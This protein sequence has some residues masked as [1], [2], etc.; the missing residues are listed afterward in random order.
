MFEKFLYFLILFS[1]YWFIPPKQGHAF[2]LSQQSE[3][4]LLT[5]SPGNEVYSVYGHSAIRVK[6]ITRDWDMVFNYGLFDFSAPNFLYRFAKGHTDYLLGAYEFSVFVEEYVADQRSIYEQVLNLLDAEKQQVFDFL[7]WNARPE[8]R[9]YRY[10]FFFDNCATR[11]RDL[12]Q[13]QAE[14]EVLFPAETRYQK[15]FRDLIKEYHSKMA[16]LNFGIDLIV[17]APS[18]RNASA[19]EEMFL[20]DYL[21]LHFEN[22]EIHYGKE[23]RPLVKLT[24]PV[25]TATETN[26]I[27]AGFPGPLVVFGLMLL[28]VAGLS[29]T[30]YRNMRNIYLVDYFVFG[31]TGFTGFVMLWFVL[32]SEHPAMAPNFNLLWAFPLN[33][34]FAVVWKIKKWRQVSRYYFPV[35]SVWYMIFLLLSFLLPQHFHAVFY[36]ITV[37]VLCRSIL[38]TLI[39][40]HRGGQATAGGRMTG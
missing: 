26:H 21:M 31:L 4:S 35:V 17:A 30:Q 3:I 12:I 38:N 19:F 7:L 23:I 10:N 22:T 18:D 6:D 32:F 24:R 5:C 40:F 2:Q 11:V 36:M 34:I 25:Y 13:N 29:V 8:N 14:G 1:L 16:W 15:T 33:L 39:L 20:P 37:M 9:V 27:G 28:F